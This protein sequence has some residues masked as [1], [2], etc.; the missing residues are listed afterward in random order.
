MTRCYLRTGDD[1]LEDAVAFYTIGS[2]VRDFEAT[3]RELDGY[4]QRIEASI[5]IASDFEELVEYPDYVLSLGPRGGLRKE[6][7]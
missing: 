5:H 7:A 6:A 2:A 4:G 3:A 1:A